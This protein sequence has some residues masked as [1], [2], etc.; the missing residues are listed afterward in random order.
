M[1]LIKIQAFYKDK[2][3]GEVYNYKDYEGYISRPM[4]LEVTLDTQRDLEELVTFLKE[5]KVSLLP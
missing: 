2:L 1:S 5:N 3:E 4:K